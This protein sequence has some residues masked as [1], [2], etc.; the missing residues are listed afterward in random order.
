MSFGVCPN[1]SVHFPLKLQEEIDAAH[2]FTLIEAGYVILRMQ[3]GWREQLAQFCLVQQGNTFKVNLLRHSNHQVAYIFSHICSS[4]LFVFFI[5]YCIYFI[6]TALSI[7]IIFICNYLFILTKLLV[8]VVG[9]KEMY[10]V[11]FYDKDIKN[12][13]NSIN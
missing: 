2:I 6:E 1:E 10:Y 7:N 9:K 8:Y 11:H 3:A 12:N 13:N 5:F 4:C